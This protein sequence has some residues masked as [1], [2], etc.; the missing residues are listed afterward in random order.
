MRTEREGGVAPDVME[1]MDAVA[2]T[3]AK[4]KTDGGEIIAWDEGE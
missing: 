3:M 4:L 1:K 2:F